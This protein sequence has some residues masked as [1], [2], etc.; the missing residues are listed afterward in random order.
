[1]SLPNCYALRRVNPFSGVLQVIDQGDSRAL[2]TDGYHWEIQVRIEQTSRGWG[3][4]NRSGSA[5]RFYRHALWNPQAGLRQMPTD[6]SLDP[7]QLHLSCEAVIDF[8][9]SES[10]QLLPFP[11]ADSYELWLL[12]NRQMPLA[13]L[14]ATSD[15][16]KITRIS[17][18][19]WHAIA[20]AQRV[21]GF[22]QA[23]VEQLERAVAAQA[24]IRQWFKRDNS[25][26]GVGLEHRT[27]ASLVD[28]VLPASEFPP[29]LV[30]DSWDDTETQGHFAA[31]RSYLS[32][33]LLLLQ[34]LS[35]TLRSE[36]E[37]SAIDYPAMLDLMHRLYPKIVNRELINKARVAARIKAA[38]EVANARWET[39]DP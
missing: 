10:S 4:L 27:R 19:R 5:S 36:L 38:N 15:A 13:L 6:P 3:S 28:R 22:T 11:F 24:D 32:P 34:G 12:D 33:W 39:I 14:A 16:E 25:G 20:A 37:G 29:L 17:E 30:R 1:M 23:Q 35:D 31:W 26:A 18:Q 2:S 7:L 9:R 8:L 21:Q